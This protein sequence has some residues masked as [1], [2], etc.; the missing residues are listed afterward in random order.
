MKHSQEVMELSTGT[1]DTDDT[2]DTDIEIHPAKR[3][4]TEGN[5]NKNLKLRRTGKP[6]IMF[7]VN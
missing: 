2:D 7:D 4:K 3:A 6:L 1:D 5:H